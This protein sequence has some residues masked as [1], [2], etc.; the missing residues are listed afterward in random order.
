M[1]LH[2]Y[3]QVLRSQFCDTLYTHN[4]LDVERYFQPFSSTSYYTLTDLKNLF[5]NAQPREEYLCQVSFKC[6]VL[7]AE[8]LRIYDMS[9]DSGQ[10]HG[11]TDGP[12]NMLPTIFSGG[13]KT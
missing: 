1:S 6:Q 12:K 8:I 2:T 10:T 11:Q 3:W 13:T 5:S 7:S 4:V 9:M